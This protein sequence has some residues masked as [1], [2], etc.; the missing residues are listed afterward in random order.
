MHVGA[1]VLHPGED[2]ERVLFVAGCAYLLL[3]VCAALGAVRRAALSSGPPQGLAV[4]LRRA[5]GAP[6][7]G[8]ES[9]G[10]D[11][12]C[13]ELEKKKLKLA[14]QILGHANFGGMVCIAAHWSGLPTSF[15]QRGCSLANSA[16]LLVLWVAPSVVTQKSIDWIYSAM[17]ASLTFAVSPL[18]VYADTVLIYSNATWIAA[19]GFS[20]MNLKPWL[21]ACWIFAMSA[22]A[23]FSLAVGELH[24]DECGSTN[25]FRLA[26]QLLTMSV[27]TVLCLV[28]VDTLLHQLTQ[29]ELDAA[30]S[31]NELAA[32]QSVLRS[33]CDV[34]VELDD[35]LRLRKD[36]P[37][38]RS[39]LFLNQSRSL[40]H[41]DVRIFL[42]SA[43][44]G[45]K[46]HEHATSTGQPGGELP[47]LSVAFHVSMRDSAGITLAVEVFV[48]RFLIREGQQAYLVGIREQTDS[49]IRG[50]SCQ[51]A[52]RRGSGPAAWAPMITS[53]MLRKKVAEQASEAGLVRSNSSSSDGSSSAEVF[54]SAEL[55]AWVDLLSPDW[56]IASVTDA[57][58]MCIGL[59]DE[60]VDFLPLVAVD[61]RD[62]LI[63][64][65]QHAHFHSRDRDAPATFGEPISFC[66]VYTQRLNLR[67]RASLRL[68]W[69]PPPGQTPQATHVVRLSLGELCWLSGSR[70]VRRRRRAPRATPGAFRGAASCK[71]HQSAL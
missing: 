53:G 62:R 2:A 11:A 17:M 8:N 69:C 65:V 55:N 21:N 42:A 45:A 34:V 38:L 29:L 49:E 14:K 57:L 13:Q 56:K 41:E 6:E 19:V 64:F 12:A 33:V 54:Q 36:S 16:L 15:L 60:E 18:A 71:A 4:L 51:R 10:S 68:D 67:L 1:R 3:G 28:V 24:S 70:R 43:E 63:T 47:R 31:R 40:Q 44:D 61:Q 25:H 46:F 32:A 52:S 22:M 27:V 59:A 37:E 7:P 5:R 58:Q 48:V 26:L 9:G 66:T 20:L 35:A 39:M 23:C 50:G 30:S